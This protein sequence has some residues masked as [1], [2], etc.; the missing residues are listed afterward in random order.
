MNN[1]INA[2]FKKIIRSK[3]LIVFWLF[4]LFLSYISVSAFS[5]SETY[6]DLFSKFYGLAPL[7]GILMFGM[8]SG[9]FVLEYSSNMDS[10]VKTTKNGKD[11]LV[12]AKGI[13]Y[14]VAASIVNLSIFILMASKAMIVL[15]F[16]G[17]SI[18]L[19]NLWY[20]GNSGSN[21]TVLQLMII[22]IITVILGSFLFAQLGLW[23]SSLS[24][25]AIVPF[26]IGGVIMGAPYLLSNFIKSKVWGFLPLWG[27]YSGE[28]IRYKISPIA[29][30]VFIVVVFVGGYILNNITKKVFSKER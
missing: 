6:A 5:V 26:F 3:G 8:F 11:K 4:S 20:F 17:L 10:I 9:S 7:M 14:G 25:K 27:M 28:L 23:I 2:E 13:A 21:I 18:P 24:K 12:L 30:I 15:D 19:K 16:K 1:I 22:T 29:F